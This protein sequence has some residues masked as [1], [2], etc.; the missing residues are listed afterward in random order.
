ML[1]MY[2][3]D[4]YGIEESVMQDLIYTTVRELHDLL[5]AHKTQSPVTTEEALGMIQ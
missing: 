2:F 5:Q 1:S 3:G 4:V